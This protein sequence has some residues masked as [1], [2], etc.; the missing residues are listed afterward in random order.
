MSHTYVHW[1]FDRNLIQIHILYSRIIIFIIQEH[2]RMS[3]HAAGVTHVTAAVEEEQGN[4]FVRKM[5]PNFNRVVVFSIHLCQFASS[6][7]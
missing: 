4:R 6:L 7:R 3:D 1:R 2:M 5:L